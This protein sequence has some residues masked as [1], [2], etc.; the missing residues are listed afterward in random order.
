MTEQ[1]NKSRLALK[2]ILPLLI[3]FIGFFGFKMMGTLKKI[4]QRQQ[5]TRQGV[6]VDVVELKAITHQVKVHA[7]GT[8]QAEQEIA[9]VPEISG[10]VTWVSPRLVSGGLFKKGET[11]LRIDTIDFELATEKARAEIARVQ[12]AMAT[13]QERAKVALAEWERI[14]I[15]DKG[16][17]G[18]L[19]TREIQLRQQQAN[20]AAAKANLQQAQLNLQRTEIKAPFNGRIRKEQVDLGQYLRAGTSIGTFAGTDRAEIHIPLPARELAW[21]IIPSATQQQGSTATIYQPDHSTGRQGKLVRQVGEVDPNSRMTTVVVMVEDPYLLQKNSNQTPLP[22]GLFV[23][24]EL[25]GEVFA[26][27]I[28][29]PRKALH[30]GDLVWI[31]DSENRLSLRQVEVFRREQQQILIQG[32]IQSGEKLILTALSGAAEGTLLRPI[33]QESP[34]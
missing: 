28:S 13:E 11:L 16:E 34:K 8:V 24:V 32:G 20:L 7:T 12:V 26:D 33:L 4:P 18:P 23:N 3:L 6:L 19:V 22:N 17:P 27:I 31:A 1:K 5:P 9:L 14:D 25:N 2:I 29:I 10:K 30:S 21:L 15:V